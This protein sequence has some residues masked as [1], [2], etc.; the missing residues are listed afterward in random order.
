MS[1]ERVKSE[2]KCL[3]VKEKRRE[4]KQKKREK[5]RK[6]KKRPG[7]RKEDNKSEQWF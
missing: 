2:R 7:M 1:G 5:K 6:E 3:C 4:K